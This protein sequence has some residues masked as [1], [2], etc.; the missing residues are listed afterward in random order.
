MKTLSKSTNAQ[1]VQRSKD[2]KNRTA[3]GAKMHKMNDATYALRRNIM[4]AIY[5]LKNHVELP[6]IEVRIVDGGD[7]T[8]CGMHILNQT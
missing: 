6:R 3:L 5:E 1:R 8:F 4:D 2:W 7:G